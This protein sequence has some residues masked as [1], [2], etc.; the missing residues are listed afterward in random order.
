[1][2]GDKNA[3][4]SKFCWYRSCTSTGRPTTSEMLVS[5]QLEIT[6]WQLAAAVL[7]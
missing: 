1:M 2:S 6:I 5:V 3:F 7:Q 4:L